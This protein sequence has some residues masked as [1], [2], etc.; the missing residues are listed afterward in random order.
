[1]LVRELQKPET[2]FDTL[3]GL[4]GNGRIDAG[5]FDERREIGRKVIAAQVIHT[6]GDP[7]VIAIVVFP[8]MLV[9]INF[10]RR[11]RTFSFRCS[12]KP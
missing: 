11:D 9:R 12:V 6:R 5:G 7:L 2:F 1:M 8:E 10:H 3:P 4:Y